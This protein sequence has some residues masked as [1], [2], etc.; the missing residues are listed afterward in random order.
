MLACQGP[1]RTWNTPCKRVGMVT[2]LLLAAAALV[3]LSRAALAAT[4]GRALAPAE[5]S[6]VGGAYRLRGVTKSYRE[7]SGAVTPVLRGVDLDIDRHRLTA[8]VGPSGQGKSTLLNLLG[9]LDLP[10]EGEILLSGRPVGRTCAPPSAAFVFQELNLLSHLDARHNVALPLLCTGAP[11]AEAMNAAE[12]ALLEVGLADLGRRLPAMLSRGQ[13]QRVAVARAVASRAQV[14]LADEPTAS[15]DPAT[16]E[17]VMALLREVVERDRTVVL[18]T[19]DLSLADRYC[20]RIVTCE[21]G[22]FRDVGRGEMP[23]P[24]LRE[25]QAEFRG[26]AQESAAGA[27]A[28]DRHADREGGHA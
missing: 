4:S 18:V 25:S 12:A 1:Q 5:G 19:H 22:R 27:D 2:I 3:A 14:I 21:G 8:V 24:R 9:G 20:D 13:Q 15:L 16:A 10:D 11:R 23:Q 17:G 28:C 26:V 6:R 7:R